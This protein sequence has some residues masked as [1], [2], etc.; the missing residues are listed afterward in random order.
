MTGKGIGEEDLFLVFVEGKPGREAAYRA[1]FSGNH[2][3]DMRALA[4]VS[5]AHAYAFAD[6]GDPAPSELCAIYEFGDGPAVL[7][8]IGRTKGTAALPQSDDQGRMV[9]RLF[10]TVESR[11]RIALPSG[12]DVVLA[13]IGA[14]RDAPDESA[15]RRACAAMIEQGATYA[16]ALRLSPVQPARG[17]EYGAAVVVAWDGASA[18]ALARLAR[19]HEHCFPEVPRRVFL[20]RPLASL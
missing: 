9:W 11:P 14:A 20:A 5:S 19:E 4:G 17:S 1:W 8:T 6:G 18:G 2:M 15:L 12:R 16:R 3:T 13:L 10:E 7:E